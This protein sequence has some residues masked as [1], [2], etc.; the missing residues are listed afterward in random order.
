L[1]DADEM[2]I[3]ADES[4]PTLEFSLDEFDAIPGGTFLNAS[5]WKYIF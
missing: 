2:S 1:S 3:V 5:S 4:S